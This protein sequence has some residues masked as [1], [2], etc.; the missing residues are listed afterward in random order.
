MTE[1]A[2]SHC[3]GSL[4]SAL[5]S[6]VVMPPQLPNFSSDSAASIALRSSYVKHIISHIL[7]ERIF[8]PFLFTT[9]RDTATNRIFEEISQ[10]LKSKSPKSESVWRQQSLYA[11]YTT[12]SAKQSVNRVAAGAVEEI[13]EQVQHLTPGQEKDSVQAAV[14]KIVK[15][16]AETWRYARLEKEGIR[17]SM[18]SE[19]FQTEPHELLLSVM[20]KIWRE[21]VEE[22][23]AGSDSGEKTTVYLQGI[24]LYSNSDI[25][26]SRIAELQPP[27]EPSVRWSKDE[28]S[29][30][31]GYQGNVTVGAPCELEVIRKEE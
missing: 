22:S 8:Q 27:Q 7:L 20:P 15:I 1:F 13:M 11:A 10:Q 17:A 6:H 4:Q 3:K 24:A 16:A 2:S 21:P 31:D 9:Q 5:P 19:C 26:Q 29:R 12:P 14:R 28:N 25:I 23:A 30:I 18:A